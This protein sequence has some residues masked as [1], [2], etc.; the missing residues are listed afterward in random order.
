LQKYT[1]RGRVLV[2]ED[3]LAIAEELIDALNYMNFETIGPFRTSDDALAAIADGAPNAAILDV[4][5][6]NGVSFPVAR[7]LRDIGVPFLFMTGSVNEVIDEFAFA[8]A[9]KKPVRLAALFAALDGIL[10]RQAA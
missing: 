6:A 10:M 9:L 8:P 1:S 5:L 2:V 3:D 4:R 7:R